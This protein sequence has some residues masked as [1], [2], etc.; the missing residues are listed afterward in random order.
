MNL[1]RMEEVLIL[2]HLG[3][4][5]TLDIIFSPKLGEV[6]CG[7]LGTAE[8]WSQIPQVPHIPEGWDSAF[9]GFLVPFFKTKKL[10]C[11]H[12]LLRFN[13]GIKR[14][15]RRKNAFWF[16]RF[17]KSGAQTWE[18]GGEE[19]CGGLFRKTAEVRGFV[20]T[21]GWVPAVC[22]CWM[23]VIILYSY[24]DHYSQSILQIDK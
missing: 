20:Q 5:G 7:T 2:W 14:E 13:L 16:G 12:E 15:K 24:L 19:H 22:K 17:E 21:A 10:R 9:S 4:W 1:S 8:R 6:L 23:E 18:G 11:A 3:Y